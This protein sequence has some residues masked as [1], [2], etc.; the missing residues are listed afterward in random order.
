MIKKYEQITRVFNKPVF[1]QCGK[2]IVAAAFPQLDKG[3]NAV[4]AE[5]ALS[6]E[7]RIFAACPSELFLMP[8]LCLPSQHATGKKIAITSN[9]SNVSGELLLILNLQQYL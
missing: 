3:G 1:E 9:W 7:E 6:M 2:C 8:I 4:D 5:A